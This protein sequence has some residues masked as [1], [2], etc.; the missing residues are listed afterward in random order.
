MTCCEDDIAFSGVACVLP[1]KMD[2]K[3]RDW[4]EITAKI[5]LKKHYVYKGKGPVLMAEK[6][7]KCEAPEEQLA[8]F[9]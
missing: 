5:E 7:E 8:V 1:V 6:V 9:Y 3:T 4:L 2:V